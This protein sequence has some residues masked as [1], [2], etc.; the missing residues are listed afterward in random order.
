MGGQSAA[1]AQPAQREQP[2]ANT[3]PA[4]SVASKTGK[5][6]KPLLIGVAAA[7]ILIIAVF[8]VIT[9]MVMPGVHFKKAGKRYSSEA[10]EV[11]AGYRDDAG[12]DSRA[13]DD[14]ASLAA[15][16]SAD[17]G[18]TVIFGTYEQDGDL[19]NGT[20]PI[21]WRVLAEEDG[22]LLLISVHGLDAV[23]FNDKASD[24]NDYEKSTLRAWAESF[25]TEVAFSEEGQGAISDDVF[26]LSIE[27]AEKYFSSDDDRTC[28]PTEY[29]KQRGVTTDVDDGA[30]AW[31]LRSP[32]EGGRSRAADV[33]YCPGE[34]YA[35]GDTVNYSIE[36]KGGTARPAVWVDA[37]SQEAAR[38]E[39]ANNAPPAGQEPKDTVDGAA[40]G[41]AGS[42][43]PFWGVWIGAFKVF[44]D[45]Q[46]RAYEAQRAGLPALIFV[47]SDWSNLNSEP[48]YVVSVGTS[49]TEAEAKVLRQSA[50]DAGY[51]DAYVK[52]SGEH[53]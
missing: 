13:E 1:Y 30:C 50:I 33:L 52:Y 29:A 25:F 53:Q 35:Y 21:E 24:G 46:G 44:G 19:S 49:E 22:K 27:E 7:A 36:G 45:A 5:S 38:E 41:S 4:Q 3:Q 6:K 12:V 17:V 37:N 40:L 51:A 28:Y 8:L 14:A 32:G 20:E 47:T 18:D 23:N 9:L 10:A 48:W 11:V 39:A 31:W 15:M 34:V 26:F 16:S 2:T 42:Q 43:T